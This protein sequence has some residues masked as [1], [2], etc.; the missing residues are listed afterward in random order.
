MQSQDAGITNRVGVKMA[1]SRGSVPSCGFAVDAT[2]KGE[3]PLKVEKRAKGKKVTIIGNVNGDATRLSRA[4]QTML[5][6]GGSVRQA[7]RGAWSV[8]VQGDQVPRVTKA[9]LDFQCLRGLSSSSLESARTVSETRRTESAVDRTAATKFLAQ[10]QSGAS[11]SPEEE[12]RRLLEMEAEFYGQFWETAQ[13]SDDFLDVFEADLC[14]SPP[15]HHVDVPPRATKDGPELNIALQALG[16]LAECGKAVREFWQNSGMSLQQFRKMAMNP[17]ARMIGEGPGRKQTPTNLKSRQKLSDWRSVGRANYFS[18]TVSAIDNYERHGKA[19]KGSGNATLTYPEEPS[20]KVEEDEEG[21]CRALLSYAVPLPVP[22]S[23]LETEEKDQVAK[24]ALRS[25]EAVLSE[26]FS[27]VER[28]IPGVKCFLDCSTFGLDLSISE[29]DFLQGQRRDAGKALTNQDKDEMRL[30]K[31]LREIC[32]LKRRQV[33]GEKLEKLQDKVDCSSRE[34]DPD[35]DRIYK[36]K[37]LKGACWFEVL[38][39][40]LEGGDSQPTKNPLYYWQT[41]INYG[42]CHEYFTYYPKYND[43]VAMQ[44]VTDDTTPDKKFCIAEGDTWSPQF[45]STFPP[46]FQKETS[47]IVN[48]GC[49]KKLCKL[50]KSGNWKAGWFKQ[51]KAKKMPWPRQMLKDGH[52]SLGYEDAFHKRCWHGPRAFGD[53]LPDIEAFLSQHDLTTTSGTFNKKACGCQDLRRFFAEKLA[54]RSELFQEVA[55]MKLRRAEKELLRLFKKKHKAF[56]DAFWNFESQDLYKDGAAPTSASTPFGIFNQDRCEG[57][58]TV[59]SD[60]IHAESSAPRWVGV[61]LHL[62]LKNGEVAAFAVEILR[63][64]VHLGW[65]RPKAALSDLGSDEKGFAFRSSGKKVTAGALEPYGESFDVGDTIH[66]EAEREEGRLRI[67]FAKNSEPLGV[68]FDV[69][70]GEEREPMLGVVAGK[71][72]KVQLVSAECMPL[73]EG[74]IFE[75]TAPEPILQNYVSYDPPRLAMV[76]RDFQAG[77]EENLLLWTGETVYVSDNDGEGWLYGFFL[78]PEDPDDG[79]WFPVDAVEFM[80]GE[81]ILMEAIEEPEQKQAQADTWDEWTAAAPEELPQWGQ[82]E[83]PE[84]PDWGDEAAA[85]EVEAETKG[86]AEDG[87]ECPVEGLQEWLQS[88]SL[89]HYGPKAAEWCVEMG[90]VSLEEIKESWED[91]AQDLSLKP[92]ET[93]RLQKACQ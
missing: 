36:V 71:N 31:K 23:R 82:E 7:E 18:P 43:Y 45:C 64:Q 53:M 15:G 34:L 91:F 41:S 30:E 79:G 1:P 17:G 6:V 33:E 77:N 5:G 67:G 20:L 78:D 25:L 27:G 37:G 74:E 21:W 11:M 35:F 90:A 10:T 4:L 32:A 89:H 51:N 16:L 52:Q 81:G 58:A 92:L 26:D 56:Q 24:K 63:G 2:K 19:T 46:N 44:S 38:T 73:E 59:S 57:S 84:L 39:R 13:S 76:V 55:E 93:K 3:L 48:D 8:E 61:P 29:G 42:Y 85:P 66:C 50:A 88:I 72:F 40:A 68:A 75:R 9:L 22:A 65:A 60:G 69:E 28:G 12:R 49:K 70:D 80:D 87:E 86:A 62:F 83:V 14:E 47:K 54:K